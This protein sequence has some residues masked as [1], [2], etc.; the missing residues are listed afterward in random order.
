MNLAT[1]TTAAAFVAVLALAG[2]A[3]AVPMPQPGPGDLAVQNSAATA[4]CFA[5]MTQ[6]E[7]S[8]WCTVQDAD[9]VAKV[10]WKNGNG[11]SFSKTFTGCKSFARIK[12]VIVSSGDNVESLTV[13]G[14]NGIKQTI[15]P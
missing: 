8:E 15:Q 2:S 10:S 12:N 5:K 13:T 3:N 9:G 14:C 7:G 4:S 1:K 11:Y 6:G